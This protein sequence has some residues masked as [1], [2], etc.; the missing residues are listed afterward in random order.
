MFSISVPLAIAIDAATGEPEALWR[1]Y[2]HPVTWVGAL[3]DR[4]EHRLNR[5]HARRQ[6]GVLALVALIVATVFPA[7]IVAAILDGLPGIFAVP[8]EA[9]LASTLIAH[10][11]LVE[12][13]GAVANA[14]SLDG[15]R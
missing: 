15:A 8:L 11:S 10:R 9:A 4:L 12:H 6:K 3:I 7:L 1:R 14:A 5:G 13:V 2:G